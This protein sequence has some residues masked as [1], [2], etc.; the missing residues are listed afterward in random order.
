MH[1]ARQTMRCCRGADYIESAFNR[2][3]GRK[4]SGLR[5]AAHF[6]RSDAAPG[7]C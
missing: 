1:G 7:W 6:F 4:Q 5:A 3:G 2:D